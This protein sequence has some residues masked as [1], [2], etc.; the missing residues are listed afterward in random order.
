MSLVQINWSPTE[1]ELRLFS[2]LWWPL[3]YGGLGGI[4]WWR[5]GSLGGALLVWGMGL[6]LH[7]AGLAVPQV[8]RG[9]FVGLSVLAFPIGYVVSHLLLG[10]IFYLLVTPL[11]WVLRAFGHDP[12]QRNFQRESATYWEPH[13]PTRDARRYF[14]QY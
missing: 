8:L 6:G 4:L 10:M 13:E 3:G 14:K 1:S 11:G 7:L 2:R 12:L 5:T 9:I